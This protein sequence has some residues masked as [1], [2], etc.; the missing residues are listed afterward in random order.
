VTCNGGYY[1]RGRRSARLPGIEGLYAYCSEPGVVFGKAPK[2][3]LWPE[4]ELET[5]G[6]GTAAVVEPFVGAG[7][8]RGNIL[9]DRS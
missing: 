8:N 4:D 9:P 3:L 2:L 5:H 6:V 7:A 1:P